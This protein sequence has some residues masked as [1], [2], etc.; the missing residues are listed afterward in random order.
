MI[1]RANAPRLSRK[2]AAFRPAIQA[3]GKLSNGS[4]SSP[5]CVG[6]MSRQVNS[7]TACKAAAR[8]IQIAVDMK[9]FSRRFSSGITQPSCLISPKGPLAPPKGSRRRLLG[10]RA[11]ASRIY[12][13]HIHSLK[14]QNRRDC[15]ATCCAQ[16]HRPARLFNRRALLPIRRDVLTKPISTATK[17]FRLSTK[18]AGNS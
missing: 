7:A 18:T 10:F 17:P 15:T 2:K 8:A 9:A 4:C 3:Q 16:I 5:R 11:P 13:Q 1:F 6:G 14:R 12:P